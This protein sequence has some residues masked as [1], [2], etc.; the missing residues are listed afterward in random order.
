M[1]ECCKQCRFF[2]CDSRFKSP[3]GKCRRYPP[4]VTKECNAFDSEFPE[5]IGNEDWCGEF[6]N[7][8]LK[9][10]DPIQTQPPLL[11]R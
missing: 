2:L 5:V 3:I 11:E 8:K 10:I 6:Q 4:T 1:R 9:M 7:R